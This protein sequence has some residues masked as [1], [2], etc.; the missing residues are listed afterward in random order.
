V[1]LPDYRSARWWIRRRNYQKFG[2]P[3]L[4]WKTFR[5]LDMPAAIARCAGRPQSAVEMAE[6][7]PAAYVAMTRAEKWLIVAAAG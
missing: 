5:R 1:I 4:C 3:R 6:R 2:G 7:L